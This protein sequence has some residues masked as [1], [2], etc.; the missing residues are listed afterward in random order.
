MMTKCPSTPG[1]L[2]PPKRQELPSSYQKGHHLAF[3]L[4]EETLQEVID[5]IRKRVAK[6]KKATKYTAIYWKV[7][8]LYESLKRDQTFVSEEDFSQ[9]LQVSDERGL[10]FEALKKGVAEAAS[11]ADKQAVV[12]HSKL[13]GFAMG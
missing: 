8:D 6:T 1:S 11:L 4:K 7:H 3:P 12:S 5:Y 13:R 9:N 10:F 2:P